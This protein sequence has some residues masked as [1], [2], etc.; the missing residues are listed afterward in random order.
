M[1]FICSKCDAQFPKWSGRCTECGAWGTVAEGSVPKTGIKKN[2]VVTKFDQNKLIDFNNIDSKQF[3]RLSLTSSE[4]NQIFGGGIVK[5]SLTLIGGEPGIGK[6]TLSLQI[7]RD[8]ET[9]NSPLLYVS[10]EESAEQIKLRID[11][12]GYKT[13]NLK[14]LSETNVE[15]IVA[16][17]KNLKPTLA[18]I[19]SIQTL[20]SSDVEGENGNINQIRAC[21]VKLIEAAKSTQVPILSP[22][23]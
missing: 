23:T 18:I 5:G 21:T 11:R 7:L 16:A 3:E 9:K 6:S 4:I 19:D 12:L 20:Y 1:L 22:G 13:Q 2:T 17:L 8:L 14:F 10:G 15:E